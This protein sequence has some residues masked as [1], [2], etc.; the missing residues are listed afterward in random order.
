MTPDGISSMVDELLD[1]HQLT[2]RIPENLWR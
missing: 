1:V 2:G